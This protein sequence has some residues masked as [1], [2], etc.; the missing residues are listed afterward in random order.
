MLVVGPLASLFYEPATD[1][2]RRLPGGPNLGAPSGLLVWTG[3]ALLVW[4]G[5]PLREQ[6]PLSD[7]W[8]PFLDGATFTPGA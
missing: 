5:D 7:D 6:V 8:W 4:G 1:R 3:K 2:W